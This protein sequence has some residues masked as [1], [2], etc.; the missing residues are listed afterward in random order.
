MEP[1]PTLPP[2]ALGLTPEPTMVA[3]VPATVTPVRGAV[4]AAQTR[5]SDTPTPTITPEPG[6]NIPLPGQANAG[7]GSPL[8]ATQPLT[9]GITLRE[10]GALPDDPGLL[11]VITPV[12]P[13][14]DARQVLAGY[15]FVA[16]RSSGPADSTASVTTTVILSNHRP[17]RTTLQAQSYGYHLTLKLLSTLQ[18]ASSPRATTFDPES[19]AR[20]FLHLHNLDADLGKAVVSTV[21]EGVTITFTTTLSNTYQVVGLGDLLQYTPAGLLKSADLHIV[22]DSS[23][24]LFSGISAHAALEEVAR[25]QG[26]VAIA[27]D[28]TLDSTASLTGTTILYM[29]VTRGSAIYLEPVYRFAGTTG[30][31]APFAVY[32]PAVDRSY[33]D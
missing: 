6:P 3:Q 7:A 27:K 24:P 17:Y 33:L 32:V 4:S 18:Q 30:S 12:V 8:D 21:T 26:L 14:A 25:G 28:A 15:N 11:P 19:N 9:P 23:P 1:A 29:P 20:A 13:A 31:G 22:D 10:V 16:Q 5:P 2:T